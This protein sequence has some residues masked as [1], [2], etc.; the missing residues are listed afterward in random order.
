MNASLSFEPTSEGLVVQMGD[1]GL[2]P[3]AEWTS[4]AGRFVGVGT[5]IRLREEGGAAVASEGDSL[6]VSWESVAALSA[7][8]LQQIGL[9]DVSPFML[10]IVA[11]G[12]I[13]DHGFDIQ[14]G[15]LEKGRRILGV[16]REGAWLRVADS[17]YVLPD[18]TYAIVEAIDAFNEG[19]EDGLE[20]RMLRWGRIAEMLPE[21]VAVNQAQLRS[22]R[23][24]VASSFK[25]DPFMNEDGEPDFDPVI[26]RLVTRAAGPVEEEQA[27]DPA[28]AD[29][30]QA[31]FAR[32]FRGLSKVKHRYAVGGG[33]YVV[34]T[35]NVEKVLGS[36]R[37]AQGGSPGGRR[38]F[39]LNVS[40]Y[41]RGALEDAPG[42]TDIDLDEV[43]SDEGLSERVKGVGI[44]V[45]KPLPWIKR[46]PEPWL[47][48]EA[49]GLRIGSQ[50]VPIQAEELPRLRE[51]I[52][53]A[54]EADVPTVLV[55]EGI[56]IPADSTTLDAVEELLNRLQPV[57]RPKDAVKRSKRDRSHASDQVL[58]VLD[59][60]DEV[61]FASR[62][63]KDREP[64]I[65]AAAPSLRTT[66]LP[67]Q[68]E[69]LAWLQQHWDAGS[70]GA[71]LADDMGLGKTLLALAFL[72]CLEKYAREQRLEARPMLVVAPTGLLRNWQDEHSKHL[73][74]RGLGVALEAHGRSLRSLRKAAPAKKGGELK[75]G[76]PI[77]D[78]RALRT[79]DWVLTTYE[80]LRDYQHSFGRI[81]WR[82]GVFDE[83]QKIKNPGVRVTEAALAMEID[84]ALLMTG[85]P[86]ENRVAD[87][88]S[89]LDRAEP[90]SFGT[91]KDF[92]ERYERGADSALPQ[93]RRTLTQ[94]EGDGWPALM[95]RRL[96][97]DHI[98]KLP[99]KRLHRMEVD[100]PP[101]QARE[102]ERVVL[103]RAEGASALQALH[104]L[105]SVSLH[106]RAPG[107]SDLEEYIQES[108]RLSKTFEILE[109]IAEKNEK[110]LLFVESRQMQDFLIVALRHRFP[111]SED[112]LV[113]NGAVSGGTRKARVDSF[114]KRTGFDAM[115]LSP[116]AGGVGLTLT[117]ANH[118]IHLSRWWNPAVEDQCTDRVFRIG[119]KRTVHVY[120][121]LAKHPRFNDYSFD[122]KLDSLMSKKR[123]LNR[124]VLAATAATDRDVEDLYRSTMT[125]AS[126]KAAD[127]AEAAW[128][129]RDVDLLEPEA[130]ESWVLRQLATSGYETRL[131]PRTGDRGADGL[132]FARSVDPPHTILVQCK[133]MQPHDTCARDAVEEVLS[134]LDQYDV[135][136]EPKPMVV[137][138]GAG[139]VAGAKDLAASQG[140]VLIDRSR[141][142]ELRTWLSDRPTP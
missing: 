22:L 8:E 39:L 95:L 84:F 123:D 57:Q 75:L 53:T 111:L 107:R 79:A 46:A 65:A 37:E 43:F 62:E 132:A 11:N 67:H 54:I 44:W 115:I 86:V 122:L 117:A 59:N 101:V 131:T 55:T 14:Y 113:I 87:I 97:E 140:V 72:S 15:F 129:G 83:A 104:R 139:F 73:S 110:A 47:P 93:L 142:P 23:I 96:K 135:V 92:S 18:P 88:W 52:Q 36:V 6:L 94:P 100:M 137:T 26:G 118:V 91:L 85:T 126:R 102:Y 9:P 3:V 119:Q 121:P 50:I 124:E 27:F 70:W 116:R 114:Q 68:S 25:L 64:G 42:E 128:E 17:E 109:T 12:S 106:P 141:L 89:L 20:S 51:A 40:G 71:L 58:I 66:L 13:L 103:D 35:P 108:A 32:Q 21:E 81:R 80:T 99:E 16:W 60:L 82:A 1:D 30:R 2:L 7:E 98:E 56:H 77:L 49:L 120:L 38:D 112:V 133:H 130:F 90:G 4:R 105:R 45:E 48:P 125:D 78:T 69:G 24:V 61:R 74:G 5:L 138:N 76:Q 28:L 31:E 34:L 10:E 33:V 19:P 134:S 41:L 29:A 127:P 63:R 136:G